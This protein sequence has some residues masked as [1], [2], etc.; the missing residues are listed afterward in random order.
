MD[1]QVC[2]PQKSR[3]LCHLKSYVYCMS[4]SCNAHIARFF[5]R[6]VV[7]GGEL[8]LQGDKMWKT[9]KKQTKFVIVWGGY[10]PSP[11]ALK[12][13]LRIDIQLDYSSLNQVAPG[14]HSR[15]LSLLNK[16]IH[17]HKFKIY[18]THLCLAKT[19][20]SPLKTAQ[21]PLPRLFIRPAREALQRRPS[22]SLESG[23]EIASMCKQRI[24]WQ[25]HEGREAVIDS[26]SH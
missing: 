15:A 24:T 1:F 6:N 17:P 13:S 22:P 25:G 10:L 23:E 26:C 12:K 18:S 4:V 9:S 21:Q 16:P 20:A 8:I 3:V 2:Q 14:R 11:K 19:A 5:F 7:Q